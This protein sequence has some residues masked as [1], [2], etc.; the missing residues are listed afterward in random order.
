[1]AR[2]EL[3]YSAGRELTRV[4]TPETE[5]KGLEAA[6]DKN[7]RQ[8]EEMVSGHKPGDTPHDPV[9]PSVLVPTWVKKR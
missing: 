9:D 1:M 4:A 7:L 3:S 5:Q 6:N 8:I 2:G